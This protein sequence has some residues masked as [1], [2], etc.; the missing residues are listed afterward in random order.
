VY[1]DIKTIDGLGKEVADAV[2]VGFDSKVAIH[3]SHV[4][5][6]APALRPPPTRSNGRVTCWRLPAMSGGVFQYEGLM[7]AA[8]VLRRADESLRSCR[9]MVARIPHW[10]RIA[11]GRTAEFGGGDD[12]PVGC[13]SALTA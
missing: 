10:T 7:V 3:P 2:A 4:A 11:V 1:L 13:E 5:S 8:P 6:F 12:G 9:R